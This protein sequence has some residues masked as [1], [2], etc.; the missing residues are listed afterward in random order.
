MEKIETLGILIDG[1]RYL[2]P[3][4]Y[5]KEKNLNSLKTVYNRIKAGKLITKKILG[6]MIIKA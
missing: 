4:Q 1:N 5:R 6:K 3:E 2:T